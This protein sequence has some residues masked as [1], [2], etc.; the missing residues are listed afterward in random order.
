MT[1]LFSTSR[2]KYPFYSLLKKLGLL[3]DN[4]IAAQELDVIRGIEKQLD[5]YRELLED[6]E[7]RT[8]YFSSPQG[9]FSSFHAAT[10][11]DYLSHLYTLR[12]LAPP[13]PDKPVNALR[14][15]PLF[16]PSQ[17]KGTSQCPNGA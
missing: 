3:P 7:R 13:N 12:Y 15:T 1:R 11:D 5:E 2:F 10:L 14:H 6:I 8:G 17:K 9:E 16:M 4:I